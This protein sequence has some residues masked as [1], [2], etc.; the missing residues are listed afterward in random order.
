ME[1]RRKPKKGKAWLWGVGFDG[2]DGHTR[3]TRGDN[4]WLTGGS[5]DTH[6]EM[7]EKAVKFN[8]KLK[9]RETRLEDITR[10]EFQQITEELGMKSPPRK[11]R[12]RED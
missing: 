12:R 8:E 1:G 6:E 11:P 5:Q 2:Q 10:D 4:F 3:I 9:E 7:Q